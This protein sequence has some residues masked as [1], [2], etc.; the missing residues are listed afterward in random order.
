[1]MND[2]MIESF[3]KFQFRWLSLSKP[4]GFENETNTQKLF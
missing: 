3:Y 4:T 2:W 1:M